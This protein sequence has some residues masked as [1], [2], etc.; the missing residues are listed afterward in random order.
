MSDSDENRRSSDDEVM[1][2]EEGQG[3]QVVALY[4]NGL[5]EEEDGDE[6]DSF[7]TADQSSNGNAGDE[8]EA[9]PRDHSYLPSS[10]PLMVGDEVQNSPQFIKRQSSESDSGY[11]ELPI[12]E[13]RGVVLFPGCTIPVK[14]RDRSLIQY[15]GRQ[16]D[17]CR[18]LPHMQQEVRLGILTYESRDRREVRSTRLRSRR[19]HRSMFLR[20]RHSDGDMDDDDDSNGGGDDNTT[21]SE[22]P[23]PP[24]HPLIGRIG[25]IAT[26][27][28]THERMEDQPMD[29]LSNSH[30]WRR[31]EEGRELIFTAVGTSRF[32]V[33]S[34]I[35]PDGTYSYSVCR[36]EELHDKPL[37]APPVQRPLTS[38]PFSAKNI[39]CQSTPDSKSTETKSRL[40]QN[41]LAWTLSI[42]TPVPYFVY[43]RVWPWKLV[44]D[45]VIALNES[46]GRANLPCLGEIDREIL[47]PTKFSFWMASNMPFTERERLSLL[48]MHSTYERLQ[49]IHDRVKELSLR[50][51]NI[52]CSVCE[53][54][55]ATV[56]SV[57]TFGGA[58]GAT[59]NYVNGGG[60]IHQITTLRQVE[61]RK[62][63]FQGPPSTE[64]R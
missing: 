63:Y 33:V 10:H 6:D 47:E 18:N 45:M 42:I 5:Y 8:D 44:D 52:C 38:A 55:L 54:K 19:R 21:E 14:L 12:L 15:L 4:L 29:S 11:V 37:V 53:E 41:Q 7:V 16:I 58:E 35:S 51:S 56:K 22:A 39:E 28:N 9:L 31:H 1:E 59:S 17:L 2:S 36:V 13:L 25:T 49:V 20:R 57:F 32:Q 62:L 46:G 23:Q 43:Q 27:T 26:I 60:Y 50:E 61:T 24:Q 64:N 30:V 3:A 48:E 34:T 40:H